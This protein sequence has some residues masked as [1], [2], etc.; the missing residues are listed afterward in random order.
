M[1]VVSAAALN[2]VVVM[3]AF[4]SFE[5]AN[6]VAKTGDTMT[7][8]LNLQSNLVFDGNAR[9]ITGDFSN[10]TF[11]NRVAF[12]TSTANG[13]TTVYAIPNG[14]STTSGFIA[15]TDPSVTNGS[16]IRALVTSTAATLTSSFRGSG[17]TL[18]LT[19]DVGGER[20]RVDTS[21]NVGIGTSSPNKSSSST[22]L[23]VNTGTA[24]N[25]SAVE[26]SSNNTLNYHINANDSAIY[27]VAAGTRPWIV[28]TNGSE[29]ARI[30][31]SGNV[32]IGTSS[33]ASKL[34]V[35]G[36]ITA[37]G[38]GTSTIS[39][40]FGGQST[41]TGIGCPADGTLAFYAG[42]STERARIDSSGN[43]LVG[44]TSISSYK[45]GKLNV[46]GFA[47]FTTSNAGV[48][49]VIFN[50]DATSGTRFF[51]N[52]VINTSVVGSIN[53]NGTSTTYSTSSDY[54]L[55]H[56][57]QPMTGALAK[58]AQLKPVT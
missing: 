58:V 11:A 27:H 43:L 16:E 7:G 54:R 20:M 18:P 38:A 25:Y 32:G 44:T 55:K 45:D 53:S 21:G 10:A 26:W 48:A 28:Y 22:A 9:R 1:S 6:A 12:Q 23:T 15:S 34:D 3:Y 47:T 56:D 36:V 29:R 13:A 19:F 5:V 39:Y 46:N 24:A 52:F 49:S 14:S 40:T 37:G 57:I 2:D 8:A 42:T 41:K 17:T 50:N 35:N 30:D 33:P 31:S 4:S 51:T